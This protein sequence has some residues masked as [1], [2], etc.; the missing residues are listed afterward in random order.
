MLMAL[1]KD[2]EFL[3]LSANFTGYDLSASGQVV[4]RG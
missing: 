3:N 4:F 2:E 1:L